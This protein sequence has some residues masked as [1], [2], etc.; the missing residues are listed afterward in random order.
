MYD[1]YEDE[2]LTHEEIAE[3]MVGLFEAVDD[4]F[5]ELIHYLTTGLI[6]I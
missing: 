2:F 4:D 6:F 3:L 5:E 1:N